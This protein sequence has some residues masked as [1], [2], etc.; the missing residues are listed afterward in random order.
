MNFSNLLFEE[1]L[2]HIITG[3]HFFFLYEFYYIKNVRK[4]VIP[5]TVQT[6]IYLLR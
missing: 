6:K 4:F 5:H 2:L 1:K 3:N